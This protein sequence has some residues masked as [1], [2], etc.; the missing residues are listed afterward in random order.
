MRLRNLDLKDRRGILEWMKDPTINQ[1]F[2][3]APDTI[4]EETINEF[5][6]KTESDLKNKHFAIVDTNDE[7][8]GTISLKNIDYQNGNAEYAISLRQKAI[9][10]D[11]AKEATDI[12]LYIAFFELDL[13]KVY[14]NVLSTNI[15]AVRFYEKY[16][17]TFEGEF[18][19]HINIGGEY[20]S[21]K[22][23]SMLKN[24]FLERQ[25]TI[26]SIQSNKS[27]YSNIKLDVNSIN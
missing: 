16:G 25:S 6:K 5:I 1:F 9:G 27:L 26:K 23:F 18:I 12:L 14:L 3:F 11:I 2:R 20:K 24:Q 10:K 19:E 15:R 8:L 22:W 21:L 7:Y 4:S 13:N 17:L